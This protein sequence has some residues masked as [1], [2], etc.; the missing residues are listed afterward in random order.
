MEKID[1]VREKIVSKAM[2]YSNSLLMFQTLRPA[3]SIAG[4]T[5]VLEMVRAAICWVVAMDLREETG[6]ADYARLAE[7]FREKLGS[8]LGSEEKEKLR[9][10]ETGFIGPYWEY[11]AGI[12]K[13]IAEG[14]AFSNP[15]IEESLARRSSDSILYGTLAQFEYRFPDEIIDALHALQA[16]E[17]VTDCVEDY[18]E[19]KEA[20]EPNLFILYL[21]GANVRREDWPDDFSGA[22]MLLREKGVLSDLIRHVEKI[23]AEAISAPALVAFSGLRQELDEEFRLV[24]DHLG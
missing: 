4:A 7:E 5:R 10:F 12:K 21:L 8:L 1:A 18:A 15:E 16:I 22:K 6:G 13:K 20:L 2:T 23:Y 24:M 14:H 11:E 3:G 19:D 9:F 17:D